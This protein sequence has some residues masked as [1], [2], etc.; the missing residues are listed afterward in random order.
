MTNT[1]E[2]TTNVLEYE[3]FFTVYSFQY[4]P[5][6]ET[7]AATTDVVLRKVVI[8]LNKGLKTGSLVW[9]AR[10]CDAIEPFKESVPIF[11]EPQKHI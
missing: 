11:S 1:F 9:Y 8:P 3:G 6:C 2:L 10:M 4:S 5:A 7:N